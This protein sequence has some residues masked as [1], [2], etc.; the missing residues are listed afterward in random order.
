MGRILEALRGAKF[1]CYG[2]AGTDGYVPA[3]VQEEQ[4]LT[5]RPFETPRPR[6][7]QLPITGKGGSRAQLFRYFLDGSARTTRAGHVVDTEHRYLPIFIAQIAVG[8]TKLEGIGLKTEEIRSRNIFFLPDTFSDADRKRAGGCII[9][10][11]HSSRFP[12]DLDVDVYQREPDT[13][14][15]DA[16][17]KRILSCMHKMEIEMIRDLAKS[18]KVSRDSMLMVDGSLQF[19]ENLRQEGESFR[20]VVGVAKTFNLHQKVGKGRNARDVGAIIAELQLGY[21][22][23]AHKIEVVRTGLAIGGWYVRLHS[24]RRYSGLGIDEGV[25]KLE[26]FPELPFNKDALLETD[27]CDRVSESVWA[28]RHPTTPPSDARWASHLYPIHVTERLIKTRFRSEQA[29]MAYL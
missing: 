6:E 12:F 26:A 11:I 27:R 2:P 18:G 13:D 1:T 28:L 25:V 5:H 29:I 17:R 8:V 9:N 21:R 24:S 16:A 22:T 4:R 7:S 10:A 19:Y 14:P 15:R 23:A 3:S 20:N